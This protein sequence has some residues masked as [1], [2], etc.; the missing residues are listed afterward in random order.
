VTRF[1]LS[2]FFIGQSSYIV[3]NCNSTLYAQP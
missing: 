3:C 1:F 2:V